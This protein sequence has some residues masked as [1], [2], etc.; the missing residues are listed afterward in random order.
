M[1]SSYIRTYAVLPY[2]TDL[3]RGIFVAAP[4]WYTICYGNNCGETY[5]K[6]LS[7]RKVVEIPFSWIAAAF[8]SEFESYIC[9]LLISIFLHNNGL[10]V[11]HT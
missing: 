2:S 1:F 10:P 4:C 8:V 9:L 3:P 5:G 6:F 7:W 11:K